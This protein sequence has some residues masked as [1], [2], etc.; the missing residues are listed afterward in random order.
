VDLLRTRN[1]NNITYNGKAL[2]QFF[3]ENL[4]QRRMTQAELINK[5][6]ERIM[7]DYPEAD[8]IHI[9]LMQFAEEL[10]QCNVSGSLELLAQMLNE[11]KELAK[12]GFETWQ[13]LEMNSE[14]EN[15]LLRVM[16]L[17]GEREANDR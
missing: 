11:R 13:E 2:A 9:D 7:I 8:K 3:N 1:K 14:S 12:Q 5:Y 4:K 10:R 16:R 6:T 15:A 17:I